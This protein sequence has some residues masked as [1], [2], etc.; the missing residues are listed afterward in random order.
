M[1]LYITQLLKKLYDPALTPHTAALAASWGVFVAFSPLL[2]VQT[3]FM[4]ATA[5]L[6]SLS[7]VISMTVLYVVNNPLT[8]IPIALAG[9]SLGSALCSYSSWCNAVSTLPGIASLDR[10]LNTYVAPRLHMDHMS[11]IY[12]LVGCFLLA[13]LVALA[14][15]PV[16]YM[17]YARAYRKRL[18]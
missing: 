2:G 13:T 3:F 11:V 17:L 4:M 12:Y 5:P 16:V 10:A 18:L 14:S 1:F 6:L 8:M 9:Y 15:Y 7:M